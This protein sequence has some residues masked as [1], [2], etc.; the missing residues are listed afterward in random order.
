V[1]ES[2]MIKQTII[3]PLKEE[4]AKF[5]KPKPAKNKG[6]AA[7]SMIDKII[8]RCRADVKAIER[9]DED[10]KEYLERDAKAFL[11][12]RKK[13]MKKHQSIRVGDK[14]IMTK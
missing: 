8:G 4:R 12:S 7:I 14:K 11:V 1:G 9:L 5:G 10:Q 2:V 6:R 3:A 13:K